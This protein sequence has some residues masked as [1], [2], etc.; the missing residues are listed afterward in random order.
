MSTTGFLATTKLCARHYI[1]LHC[2]I[3]TAALEVMV[4]QFVARPVVSTHV[5]ARQ[6]TSPPGG[7]S[8]L[9]TIKINQI[10][11]HTCPPPLTRHYLKN[12]V[13][14]ILRQHHLSPMHGLHHVHQRR[15]LSPLSHVLSHSITQLLIQLIVLQHP[16]HAVR[17][18]PLVSAS[19]SCQYASP[20]R[21][22][23]RHWLGSEASARL[24][25]V[26]DD[27]G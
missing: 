27:S 13:P 10:I 15:H 18:H 5:P 26:F 24:R 23:P 20:P 4:A 8:K 22:L 1:T 11:K 12:L 6:R 14:H 2:M 16:F 17:F 25:Q 19:H 9:V 21:H 3:A 7:L